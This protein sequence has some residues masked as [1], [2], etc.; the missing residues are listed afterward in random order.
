MSNIKDYEYIKMSNKRTVFQYILQ[1]APISRADLSRMTKMSPTTITRIVKDLMDEGLV[2]E[3]DHEVS[4]RVGRRAIIIDAVDEAVLTVGVFIDK[5][6]LRIGILGLKNELL[7][8]EKVALQT[9]DP[10]QYIEKLHKQIDAFIEAS[11]LNRSRIIGIG[12]GVPGII[13]HENGIVKLS[14]TLAWQEV[15]LASIIEKELNIP[16]VIDNELK[17]RALAEYHLGKLTNLERTAIISFG[18]GV[19]SALIVNDN[20]YRGST[21]SAG[22][23]GHTTVDINGRRCECGKR[24]CLQTYII[25]DELVK[26]A[27]R[28]TDEQITQLDDIFKHYHDKKQW[29][30]ELIEQAIEYIHVTI[31]NVVCMYNPDTVIIDGLLIDKLQHYDIEIERAKHQQYVWEPL[32][33]S[34]QLVYSLLG[35]QGVTLG[36]SLLAKNHFFDVE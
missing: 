27:K 3:V 2:K 4:N 11:G 12:I 5:H 13:D 1:E 22:E 28:N 17:A 31:S 16:T 21:N 7:A 29:A 6:N 35:N 8:Y 26:V 32:E 36:A 19:G 24:G 25:E 30:I 18:S 33:G 15:E 9:E 14:A 23:I 20:I 10:N 34:Y